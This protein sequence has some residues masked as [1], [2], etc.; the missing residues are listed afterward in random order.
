MGDNFIFEL[1]GFWWD[2]ML[3]SVWDAGLDIEFDAVYFICMR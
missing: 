3:E 1:N 2:N